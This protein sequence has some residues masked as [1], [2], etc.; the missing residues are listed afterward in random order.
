MMT[1]EKKAD[2]S[3]VIEVDVTFVSKDIMGKG[4]SFTTSGIVKEA[5]LGEMMTTIYEFMMKYGLTQSSSSSFV[6]SVIMPLNVLKDMVPINIEDYSEPSSC[7][8]NN[9]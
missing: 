4:S 9:G 6:Q 7:R 2:S 3:G 8:D 5:L 1:E